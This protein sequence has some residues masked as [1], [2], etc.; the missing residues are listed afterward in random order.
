MR[1][2]GSRRGR[3]SVEF[4]H[5]STVL[6]EGRLK[7]IG[8]ALGGLAPREVVGRV[9]EDFIEEAMAAIDQANAMK[10]DSPG[11]DAEQEPS[12]CGTN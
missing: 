12:Q 7:F 3:I 11:G 2:T 10:S 5:T 8:V 9:L 1:D 4:V 6:A